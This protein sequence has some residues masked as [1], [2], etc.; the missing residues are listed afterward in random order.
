[1]LFQ[2]DISIL[3]RSGGRRSISV[4]CKQTYAYFCGC[5]WQLH[6]GGNTIVPLRVTIYSVEQHGGNILHEWASRT[7]INH[8]HNSKMCMLLL[9]ICDVLTGTLYTDNVIYIYIVPLLPIIYKPTS[10]PISFSDCRL[11]GPNIL[12]EIN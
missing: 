7:R 2:E 11:R 8:K 4:N 12:T 1:M 5:S 3:L 6:L 10:G 9:F